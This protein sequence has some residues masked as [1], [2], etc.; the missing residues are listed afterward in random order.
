MCLGG[1]A[2]QVVL[3]QCVAESLVRPR[4]LGAGGRRVQLDRRGVSV[5]VRE[6]GEAGV[7]AGELLYAVVQ[8]FLADLAGR[9]V[10]RPAVECG[11][12]GAEVPDVEALRM[13]DEVDDDVRTA[14]VSVEGVADQARRDVEPAHLA[15]RAGHHADA[16]RPGVVPDERDPGGEI[17]RAEDHGGV[18]QDHVV[19]GQREVVH[20]GVAGHRDG[21]G[22]Q[23]RAGVAHHD[24]LDVIGAVAKGERVQFAGA[25]VEE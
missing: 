4:V 11:A 8:A 2:Y 19:V 5:P 24:V 10:D 21:G 14:L 13:A 17:G 25:R 3:E 16:C 15:A 7:D 12:A 1:A 20:V 22:A 6:P 9:E 23:H 18:V